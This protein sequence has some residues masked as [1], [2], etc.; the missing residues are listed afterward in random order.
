MYL[1]FHGNEPLINGNIFRKCESRQKELYE[2]LSSNK[3][4]EEHDDY[5]KVN[6]EIL[7]SKES[8]QKFRQLYTEEIHLNN[9]GSMEKYIGIPF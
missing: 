2:E 6:R 3:Y 1:Y 8:E 9:S 7:A 5:K 4:D